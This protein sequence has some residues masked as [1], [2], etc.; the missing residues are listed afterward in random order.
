MGDNK[1][2][3]RLSD[4]EY[5]PTTYRNVCKINVKG[6]IKEEG[7]IGSEGNEGSERIVE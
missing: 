3:A 6:D 5:C 1:E 4:Q 7:V 2:V